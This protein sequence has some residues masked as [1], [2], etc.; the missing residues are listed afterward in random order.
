MRALRAICL[1]SSLLALGC[2]GEQPVEEL[3]GLL[4]HAEVRRADGDLL[5][6]ERVTRRGWGIAEGDAEGDFRWALGDT[7]EIG[8]HSLAFGPTTAGAGSSAG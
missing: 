6:S 1:G 7:A 5:F 8:F 2:S 3:L 4:P